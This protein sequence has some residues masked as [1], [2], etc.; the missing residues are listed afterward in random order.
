ME[1]LSTKNPSNLFFIDQL[2][3][4]YNDSNS[5]NR[6]IMHTFKLG[7]G[8]FHNMPNPRM[9]C[10]FVWFEATQFKTS[11]NSKQ[12]DEYRYFNNVSIPK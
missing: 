12:F 11:A 10:D 6:L 4:R 2:F 8:V 1:K 7:Q 9:S 3:L 5:W